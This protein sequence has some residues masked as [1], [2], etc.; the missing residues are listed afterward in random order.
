MLLRLAGLVLALCIFCGTFAVAVAGE[1]PVIE[2]GREDEVMALFAPYRLNGELGEGWSLHRVEILATRIEVR[3]VAS[4]GREAM[5]FLEHPSRTGR[6]DT[7]SF[8]VVVDTEHKPPRAFVEPLVAAVRSHDDGDFWHITRTVTGSSSAEY[9]DWEVTADTGLH[10]WSVDGLLLFSLLVGT[11]GLLAYRKL[12]APELE[13]DDPPGDGDTQP[14]QTVRGEATRKKNPDLLRDALVLVGIAGFGAALRLWMV[15]PQALGVWPYSRFEAFAGLVYDGPGLAALNRVLARVWYQTDIAFATNLAFGIAA[16]LVVFVHAC[17]LLGNRRQALLAALGLC[18]LPSHIRFSASEVAF[19]PSIVISSFTFVLLH[20]S[21]I[22]RSRSLR[23]GATIGLGF[24]T[25]AMLRV[26]PL[27]I[28]FVVV[29]LGV[30]LVVRARQAPR[31]RRLLI[32][33][34]L[35]AVGAI[36]GVAYLGGH[37]SNE[38][39]DGMRVGVLFEA[40][41]LLFDPVHNA[42]INPSITPPLLLLVAGVGLWHSAKEQ[43]RLAGLLAGWLLLFHTGHAYVISA[44]PE[45]Q[46]R[47]YLHMAVPLVLLAALGLDYLRG[48]LQARGVRGRVLQALG[49]AYVLAIPWMHRGFIRDSDFSD[50]REYAFVMQAREQIGD[51]C[52][53]YEFLGHDGVALD[54]RFARA[55][56]VIEAGVRRN[57]IRTQAVGRD[58]TDELEPTDLRRLP[59]GLTR[60]QLLT[61]SYLADEPA[62]CAYLYVGLTC[63][64]YKRVSQ[65]IA[66][67]CE[68]MVEGQP[69]ELVSEVSFAHRRYDDNLGAGAGDNG[70]DIRLTLYRLRPPRPPTGG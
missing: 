24:V 40:F 4:D 20:M 15:E 23:L 46:A 6:R 28:L 70:S 45:M 52:T 5:F 37:Y 59:S 9:A 49:M 34:L 60:E 19:I 65:P 55:G 54:G 69:V 38:V 7:P 39:S 33:G 32:A 3:G 13:G 41:K 56:G 66:P 64:G 17:Y 48:L 1:R 67:A 51:G 25:A 30:A 61:P 2:A 36:V 35:V 14:Q 11:T 12:R 42:L 63:Y 57:T 22:E 31:R 58:L 10:S 18:V 16:P 47:Y 43:P 27:N 44:T 21:L 50:L 29:F 26:R 62:Q 53:V 68:A 8:A